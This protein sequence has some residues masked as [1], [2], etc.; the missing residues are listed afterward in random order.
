MRLQIQAERVR[1]L[2][3]VEDSDRRSRSSAI[4]CWNITGANH[5]EAYLLV[6]TRI[7]PGFSGNSSAVSLV[8]S[9][10]LTCVFGPAGAL[11]TV[12]VAMMF[13]A[14]YA[15]LLLDSKVVS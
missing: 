3:I 9:W 13:A 6:E 15:A 11:V 7:G 4:Q 10:I 2:M 5:R 1:R 14:D 8:L 12:V